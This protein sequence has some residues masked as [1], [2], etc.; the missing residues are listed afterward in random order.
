MKNIMSKL[1]IKNITHLG[2]FLCFITYL[3]SCKT[4]DIEASGSSNYHLLSRKLEVLTFGSQITTLETNYEYDTTGAIPKL[5]AEYIDSYRKEYDYISSSHILV[6]YLDN[7]ENIFFTVDYYIDP[8]TKNILREVQ[9]D[10]L[11]YKYKYNAKGFLIGKST[12]PGISYEYS[13]D[14]LTR[15]IYNSDYQEEFQYSKELYLA[16]FV[17]YQLGMPN[18]NI[19]DKTLLKVTNEDGTLSSYTFVN[20]YE[21]DAN[22]YLVSEMLKETDYQSE[23]K[24][25]YITCRKK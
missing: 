9:N 16:P 12:E 15:K 14:N 25:E 22:G 8:T 17:N 7:S 19:L 1:V 13:S 5:T 10:T 3:T 24:Y 2:M 6:N 4:P 20:N 23:T 11:E 21:I 18:K